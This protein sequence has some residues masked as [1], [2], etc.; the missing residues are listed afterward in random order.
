MKYVNATI[1]ETFFDDDVTLQDAKQI[2]IKCSRFMASKYLL[3]VFH[4][5]IEEKSRP[6]VSEFNI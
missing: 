1:R 2:D 5:H 4:N 6:V 3:E